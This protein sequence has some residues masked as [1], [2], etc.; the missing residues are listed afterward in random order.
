VGAIRG[1]II[2]RQH[3]TD[4]LRFLCFTWEDLSLFSWVYLQCKLYNFNFYNKESTKRCEKKR[5]PAEVLIGRLQ[6][7]NKQGKLLR[8]FFIVKILIIFSQYKLSVWEEYSFFFSFYLYF[9]T[10]VHDFIKCTN[11]SWCSVCLPYTQK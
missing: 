2:W 3:L 1:L 5:V 10:F 7:K 11:H 6:W 4:F 8:I 9:L